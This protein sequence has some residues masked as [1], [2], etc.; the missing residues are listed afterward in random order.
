LATRIPAA[1]GA[2]MVEWG[3]ESSPEQQFALALSKEVPL[4]QVIQQYPNAPAM[5]DDRPVNEYYYLRH[6][7]AIFGRILSGNGKAPVPSGIRPPF[8]AE[9]RE[10]LPR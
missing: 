1:A 5:E 10:A 3:P 8:R 9:P 7:P 6:H 2:D 4:A